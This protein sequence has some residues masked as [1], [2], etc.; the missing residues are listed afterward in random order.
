MAAGAARDRRG[1]VRLDGAAARGNVMEMAAAAREAWQRKADNLVRAWRHFEAG[2]DLLTSLP[3]RASIEL[4][5]N[6]NFRCNMC[7]QSW[8]PRFAK[9]NPAYNMRMELFMHI[10]EQLFP[11]AIN[12]DLRGFGETTLLPYW[13]ELVQSLEAH[14][15][16]EWNLVSNLSLARDDVWERMM[17]ANFVIGASIDAGVKSTF[18]TIRG[19]SNFDRIRHNL[20]VVRDAIRLHHSGYLYFITVVQRVNERELRQVVELAHEVGVYEVQFHIVRGKAELDPSDGIDEGVAEAVEAGLDLGVYT[21]FNAPI[22]TRRL[23]PEKLR[24]A[25]KVPLR[26]LP[27]NAFHGSPSSGEMKPFEER[28]IRSYRVVE[29]QQCMKP[30]AYANINHNGE[31]G[32]CNHL[33]YPEM[34]VMGCFES[35]RLMQIWNGDRYREFRRQLLQARPRDVRCQWCFSNRL[36]D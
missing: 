25:S 20:Q 22:F 8:D 3:F 24:R 14:P 21:T 2:D 28:L 23:D 29:N 9:Y 17:R 18:E 1:D 6:C 16:I 32:P 33:Q 12:V 34:P 11:T 27:E 13:P 26:K 36:T 35:Q 4:T 15:F 19:G 10:A 30:F 7:A 5:Q 31:M